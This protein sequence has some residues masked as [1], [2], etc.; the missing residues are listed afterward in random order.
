MAVPLHSLHFENPGA[1]PLVIL[2]GLLGRS[3]NW[4]VVGRELRER[5]DVH[6]L[7]LR[8]HG[9]SPHSDSMRW[10][11]LVA[12]LRLYVENWGWESIRLMGHS[13]GGKI[14]MRYACRYPS[15]VVKLVVVDI[16]A[17][18]YPPYHAD[19]FAAMRRIQVGELTK[20]REAEEILE[21]LVEGWGMRRFLLGNLVRNGD[22]GY[23]WQINLSGLESSLPVLRRN[24]LE[25]GDTYPGPAL[26]IAGADS[27]FVG[28]GDGERMRE[29][30][31]PALEEVSVPDAGHNVHVE[32][33]GAFIDVLG[34]W[35]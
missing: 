13:L 18:D 32:N 12:D 10:E 5:F 24:S 3:A 14:A 8:N 15:E 17:K 11:E 28:E 20:Q 1:P 9:R 16:A 33:R 22:A 4:T 34:R 27:D 25:A 31:F 29:C 21:P 23:R 26:L 19:K 2:H 30:W 6:A 35:L 7:D